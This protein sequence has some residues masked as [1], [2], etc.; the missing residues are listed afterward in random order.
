MSENPSVPIFDL[1]N[2]V[3]VIPHPNFPSIKFHVRCPDDI[4][5]ME[6][7]TSLGSFT[8]PVAVLNPKDDSPIYEDVDKDGETS[9]QLVIK[10]IQNIPVSSMVKYLLKTLVN[11]EGILDKHQRAIPFSASRIAI[12]FSP[13]LN[14]T[15]K[16][17]DNQPCW[18][19]L[20]S[21]S[22]DEKTFDSDP[23]V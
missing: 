5:K 6:Y 12:L 20:S 1:D 19:W 3:S 21:K 22:L 17:A 2:Q 14:V 9:K 10:D 16:D 23:L 18:M 11:W 13:K 7:F 4:E 8:V 15:E